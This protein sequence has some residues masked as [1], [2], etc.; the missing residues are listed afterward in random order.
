MTTPG[1]DESPDEKLIQAHQLLT[2]AHRWQNLVIKEANQLNYSLL[3]T[4]AQDTLMNTETI[5][6]IIKKL[7]P[8]LKHD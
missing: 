6:F 4:H 8:A 2:Q 3:F 1:H 5:E 7:R